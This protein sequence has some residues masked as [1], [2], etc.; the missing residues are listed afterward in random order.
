MLTWNCFA[1]GVH[2]AAQADLER[3]RNDDPAWNGAIWASFEPARMPRYEGELVV[4]AVE[5]GSQRDIRDTYR[6]KL[7]ETV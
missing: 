3:L 4:W 2:V 6:A 7:R 1:C 5:E